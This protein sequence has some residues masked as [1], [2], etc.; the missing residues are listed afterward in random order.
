MMAK[1]FF[2]RRGGSPRGYKKAMSRLG[3]LDL[4]SSKNALGGDGTWQGRS[5]R[6]PKCSMG[7]M[8]DRD[9]SP[10]AAAASPLPSAS[11]APLSPSPPVLATKSALARGARQAHGSF[12]AHCQVLENSKD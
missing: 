7:P 10:G 12:P 1:A 2:P 8:W 6:C 9:T 5:E 11:R 3:E 4:C